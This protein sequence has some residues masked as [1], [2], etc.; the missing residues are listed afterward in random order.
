MT[1]VGGTDKRRKLFSQAFLGRESSRGRELTRRDVRIVKQ[2]EGNVVSV[3]LEGGD[4][5]VEELLL[6]LRREASS[7]HVSKDFK[8]SF[9]E[10]LGS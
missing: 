10:D 7:G 2:G 5:S 3:L 1:G 4:D 6:R 9:G 8:S